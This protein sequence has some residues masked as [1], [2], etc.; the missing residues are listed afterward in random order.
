M[1]TDSFTIPAF[2][3]THAATSQKTYSYAMSDYAKSLGANIDRAMTDLLA[4]GRAGAQAALRA[5]QVRL[6]ERGLAARTINTR[7]AILKAFLAAA[8]DAELIP[9]RVHVK[10]LRS[11]PRRDTRGPDHGVIES[12]Y[13]RLIAAPDEMSV[14]DG[15]I[16]AVLYGCLLRRA[17]ICSLDLAHL[18]LRRNE[19]SVLGKHR[20]EREP[21][22]FG[23]G[24]GVARALDRWLALRGE[25]DGPLFS[26]LDS[27][28]PGGRLT[29]LR[30]WR[31]T[32]ARGVGR[33]HGLRHAGVTRLVTLGVPV[34]DIAR[35]AR[36]SVGVILQHY[37]DPVADLSKLPGRLLP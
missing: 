18:D 4:A 7:V 5:Y 9:W 15:A 14:R 20:T 30:I 35:F 3:S 31:I 33:P 11:S 22:A 28:T 26:R 13:K 27:A 8:E 24:T 16:I 36:T 25:W 37:V 10:P 6:R 34:P 21:L 12:A 17:E 32:C 2:L 1:P 23:H 29:G 19:L